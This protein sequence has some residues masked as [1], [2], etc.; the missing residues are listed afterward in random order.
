VDQMDR[1]E[2]QDWTKIYCW[3]ISPIKTNKLH[4]FTYNQTNTQLHSDWKCRC[5]L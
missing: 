3:C 5:S 1:D 2:E 4:T